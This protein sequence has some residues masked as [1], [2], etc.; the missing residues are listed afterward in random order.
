MINT[1]SSVKA[2]PLLSQPPLPAKI[3]DDASD[4]TSF[5]DM[6]KSFVGDVNHLQNTSGDAVQKMLAGEIK[7]VHQVML[8]V[9]EAKVALNLLIEIRKKVMEAYK[10]IINIR[11]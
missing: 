4:R 1:I 11:V 5:G 7:D 6:L 3:K 10:E 2:G 9:G 8:A